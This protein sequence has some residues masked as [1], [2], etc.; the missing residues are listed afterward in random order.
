MPSVVPN[1]K[2]IRAFADEAAFEAWLEKHHAS[3]P[4]VWIKI[5]KKG[6]GKPTI[7]ASQAIDVALC[8]GWIDA[9]RKPLDEEAFLQRYTPRGKKSRWS[10]INVE[11]VARLT[12]AKRMTAHGQVHIDEAKLDGRWDAAYPSPSALEMPEAFR[13]AAAKNRAA[14][15]ALEGLNRVNQYAI[16]Y[17]FHH[18]K[19][20]EG[21]ARFI[22]TWV[23]KLARGELPHPAQAKKKAKKRAT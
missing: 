6:S 1:P 4:E 14:R 16:A 10:Q 22:A 19:T 17:R 15:T 23:E 3:A 11:R 18:L 2:A 8:W 20:A 12:K 13:K 5:Y 9:I 21:K 7:S